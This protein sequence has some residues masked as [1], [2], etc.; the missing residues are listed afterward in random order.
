MFQ[1][2]PRIATYTPKTTIDLEFFIYKEN[3][4]SFKNKY[5]C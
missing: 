3:Q 4:A 2:Q 5:F 1:N